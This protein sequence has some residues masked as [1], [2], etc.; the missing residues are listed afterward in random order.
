MTQRRKMVM[1]HG[2][3]RL[4]VPMPKQGCLRHNFMRSGGVCARKDPTRLRS[5]S[6]RYMARER[7]S[8]RP[9]D[10]AAR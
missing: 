1:Q 8:K 5:L 9:V 2:S 3:T 10:G 4:N 7:S 6:G